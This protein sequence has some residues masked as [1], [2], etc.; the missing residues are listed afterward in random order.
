MDDDFDQLDVNSMKKISVEPM[1]NTPFGSHFRFP[2][3]EA[4]Q[5]PGSAFDR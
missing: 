2:F 3:G 4:R 1:P 5:R